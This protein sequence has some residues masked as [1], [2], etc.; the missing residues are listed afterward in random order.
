MEL[1]SRRT[2]ANIFE[3]AL[4]FIVFLAIV[5]SII[6]FVDFNS[7]ESEVG[8]P[9]AAYYSNPGII[10][11]TILKFLSFCFFF[12]LFIALSVEKFKNLNIL[13]GAYLF[14]AL[15][16]AFLQ[17]YELYYGSTFYYGE[18]RDKQGLGYPIL[19]SLMVT[20]IIWKLN[21]SNSKER[22][23]IIKLILTGVINIGLYQ[24]YNL[25]Y[26]SW[27]LWQS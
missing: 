26:E 17:W 6:D 11:I 10:R 3:A 12:L 20:L 5:F 1:N 19:S 27:N 21:Y 13:L 8:N 25:V 9:F 16:I 23:L 7:S 2:S 24:V 22:N 18:V 15:A 14:S 4:A